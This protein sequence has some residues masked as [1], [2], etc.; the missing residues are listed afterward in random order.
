MVG[1]EAQKQRLSTGV[2]TT[3]NKNV[4]TDNSGD[5]VKAFVEQWGRPD[6]YPEALKT[7]KVRV[8]LTPDALQNAFTIWQQNI[9]SSV[10]Q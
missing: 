3:A 4:T 1:E 9:G 5:E 8:P 7:G 6:F 2:L 10:G